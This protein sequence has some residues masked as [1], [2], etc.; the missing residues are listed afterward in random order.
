MRYQL[1]F[2]SVQVQTR[3]ADTLKVRKWIFEP[4]VDV[5]FYR[6][7][8][9]YLEH[10]QG[11]E[12]RLIKH[13]FSADRLEAVLPKGHPLGCREHIELSDLKG[14]NFALQSACGTAELILAGNIPFWN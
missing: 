3:E 12:E 1:D 2:P 13:P 11:K 5:A 4:S 7:S 8:I 10:D 6:D 14:E 9:A